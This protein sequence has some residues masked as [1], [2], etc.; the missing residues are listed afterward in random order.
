MEKGWIEPAAQ[1]TNMDY[2]REL[3]GREIQQDAQKTT[4][5]FEYVWYGQAPLNT[6]VFAEYKSQFDQLSHR[7]QSIR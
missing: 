1:K 3:N 4:F 7:I 2:V 6:T 5:I